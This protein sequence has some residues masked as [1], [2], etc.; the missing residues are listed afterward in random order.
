MADEAK[1]LNFWRADIYFTSKPK[2]R[3]GCRGRSLDGRSKL[4]KRLS[5]VGDQTW[6]T[7]SKREGLHKGQH[8]YELS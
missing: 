2:L 5:E 1:E 8:I 7:E 4:P 3:G 6:R